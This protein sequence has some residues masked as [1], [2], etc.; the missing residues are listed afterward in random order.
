MRAKVAGILATAPLLLLIACG[1][2][3]ETD[4]SASPATIR[5][6]NPPPVIPAAKAEPTAMAEDLLPNRRPSTD[7]LNPIDRQSACQPGLNSDLDSAPAYAI[8]LPFD[9][10]T[11]RSVAQL[12]EQREVLL[13]AGGQF[14]PA[15]VSSIGLGSQI[16]SPLGGQIEFREMQSDLPPGY[17][18][19]GAGSLQ[20]TIRPQADLGKSVAFNPTIYIY[21]PGDSKLSAAF[22]E[23]PRQ[24]A[25]AIV[26]R[27][28]VIVD[29]LGGQGLDPEGLGHDLILFYEADGQFIDLL[30]ENS[31]QFWVG[32]EPRVH[33]PSQG[34]AS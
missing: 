18:L 32:G 19:Y 26:E 14:V 15:H 30:A 34:P 2:G 13:G 11:C 22:A 12:L 6:Q 25:G 3:T 16:R 4:T 1:A 7:L 17:H 21:V 28:Q 9:L 5:P 24:S 20:I 29:S 10:S 8:T 33:F 23:R 27:G 31:G